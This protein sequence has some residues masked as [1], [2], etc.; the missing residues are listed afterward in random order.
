MQKQIYL[1]CNPGEDIKTCFQRFYLEYKCILSGCTAAFL[2]LNWVLVQTK[3]T[4]IKDT[5]TEKQVTYLKQ[6]CFSGKFILFKDFFI[7]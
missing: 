4:C 1:W 2:N 5:F 3:Y 6:C 7:F